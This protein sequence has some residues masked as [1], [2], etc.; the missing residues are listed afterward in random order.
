MLCEQM[1]GGKC[2]QYPYSDEDKES[3]ETGFQIFV[4][5]LVGETSTF[6]V[7]PSD[8]VDNLKGQIK[9]KEGITFKFRLVTGGHQLE[10]NRTVSDYNIEKETTLHMLHWIKGG[11][12]IL[13]LSWKSCSINLLFF[14]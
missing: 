6:N 9:V 1:H 5:N 7:K 12:K 2:P 11:G 10:D 13:I 4:K 3:E 8:T 14:M